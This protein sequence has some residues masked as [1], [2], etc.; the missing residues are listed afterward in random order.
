MPSA[1]MGLR[2]GATV[3]WFGVATLLVLGGCLG[4]RP[5]AP[6]SATGGSGG[7]GSGGSTYG[8][9]GSGGKSDAG[10]G[11]VNGSGGI[12]GAG[13]IKGSGGGAGAGGATVPMLIAPLAKD[14]GNAQLGVDTAP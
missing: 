3:R 13:G 7:S 2:V 10:A 8:G 9:G 4:A 12:T 6:D 1:R 11:G 14:F 5:N